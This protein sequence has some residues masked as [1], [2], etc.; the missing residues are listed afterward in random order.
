MN[1]IKKPYGNYYENEILKFLEVGDQELKELQP[2]INKK[3]RTK[4]REREENDDMSVINDK[5]PEMHTKIFSTNI[6]DEQHCSLLTTNNQRFFDIKTQPNEKTVHLENTPQQNKNKNVAD[7]SLN[8]EAFLNNLINKYANIKNLPVAP[9][10]KVSFVKK[11][12]FIYKSVQNEPDK[13]NI[14]IE[15]ISKRLD[16]SL[17]NIKVMKV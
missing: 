11:F 14:F 5:T 4:K 8:N 6:S 10:D 13:L 3:K 12:H 16:E 9:K 1:N 2:T 7:A 15:K 17:D